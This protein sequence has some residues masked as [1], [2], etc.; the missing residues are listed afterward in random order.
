MLKFINEYKGLLPYIVAFIAVVSVGIAIDISNW[1]E[2]RAHGFSVLFC[3][4]L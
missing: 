3:F 4:S 1:N 2:C